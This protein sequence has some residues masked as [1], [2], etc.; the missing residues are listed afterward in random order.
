MSVG[1][2]R[3]SMCTAV[4][5]IS[6]LL[7][8][9]DPFIEHDSSVPFGDFCEQNPA[10]AWRRFYI[11]GTGVREVGDIISDRQWVW[12]EVECAVA[13]PL[14][15]RA[16]ELMGNDRD[17]LIDSDLR[18]LDWTIGTAGYST[19]EDAVSG[20]VITQ[21]MRREEGEACV[22]GVL[23]LRVGYWEATP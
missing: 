7:H 9:G 8:S 10:S 18:Q 14:D 2:I 12:T 1:L 15:Y 11:R 16:G 3:Q 19:L 5:A 4:R 13:Y 21:G 23:T 6:P 22:F 20:T 17:D